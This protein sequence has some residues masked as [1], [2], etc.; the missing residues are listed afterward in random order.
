MQANEES[1]DKNSIYYNERKCVNRNNSFDI[2]GEDEQN[3]D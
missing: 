3:S 1:G 2:H